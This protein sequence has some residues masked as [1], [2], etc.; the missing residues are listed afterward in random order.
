M[1]KKILKDPSKIQKNSKI[2]KPGIIKNS[3]LMIDNSFELKY[4]LVEFRDFIFL[5]SWL[6]ESILSI[7][8][9]SPP[10][11]KNYPELH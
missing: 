6:G 10:I 3:I 1:E 5:P 4:D 8:K 7:Y 2:K 11:R 9:A